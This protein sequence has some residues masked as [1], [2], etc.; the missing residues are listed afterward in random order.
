MFRI[1]ASTEEYRDSRECLHWMVKLDIA[2]SVFKRG[3]S[4]GP[5]SGSYWQHTSF[6]ES[7]TTIKETLRPQS[8]SIPALP[9][10][11]ISSMTLEVNGTGQSSL[12]DSCIIRIEMIHHEAWWK[13]PVRSIVSFLIPSGYCHDEMTVWGDGRLCRLCLP[14]NWMSQAGI[15]NSEVCEVFGD[16]LYSWPPVDVP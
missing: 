12:P 2:G 16:A 7:I 11:S 13:L 1:T 5:H 9:I 10:R 8:S 14:R 6:E 3:T 4:T 15:R